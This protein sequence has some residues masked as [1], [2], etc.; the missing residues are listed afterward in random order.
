GHRGVRPSREGRRGRGLAV[1]GRGVVRERRVD[2]RRR[3]AGVPMSDSDDIDAIRALIHEYAFRIDAGDLDGV[4]ALFEHAELGSSVR[5]ERMR[6]AAEVRRNYNGVILY[7]NGT[8][9][10]MHCLTNVTI[11]IEK[12]G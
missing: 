10:T 9:C 6:G 7:E 8:P 2:A 1:L 5:P 3:W 11:T 12:G 4:A